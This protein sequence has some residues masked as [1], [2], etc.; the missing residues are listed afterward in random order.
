LSYGLQM[1]EASAAVEAAKARIRTELAVIAIFMILS[2][3]LAGI[4]HPE[5]DIRP[6]P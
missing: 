3:S 2:L 4:I 5:V 1:F 6:P